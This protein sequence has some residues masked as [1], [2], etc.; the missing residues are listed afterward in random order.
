MARK[1]AEVIY[2]KMPVLRAAADKIVLAAGFIT[3]ADS[4]ALRH[5]PAKDWRASGSGCAC[6]EGV[7][8]NYQDH[9]V[10]Y[11]TSG[12]DAFQR[13]LGGA[14]LPV[15]I[16]SDPDNRAGIFTS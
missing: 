8:E 14:P 2:E 6:L 4:D 10:V 7:G 15:I 3:A 9:P 13:R 12:S 1:V 5:R 11:M 16:K